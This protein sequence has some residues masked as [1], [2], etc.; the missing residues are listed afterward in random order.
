VRI[1]VPYAPGGATDIVAHLV[2]DQMRELLGQ[3]FIVES[4]P[5]D[6]GIPAIEQ[7]A[8]AKPDGYTLVVGNVSTNVITPIIFRS[9]FRIDY[10]KDVVPVTRL[11]DL[12]EFLLVTTTDFAPR[13]LPE[14]VAYA[15]E[16]PGELRYGA[17]GAGSYPDFDMTLFA[18][19]AGNLQ[20]TPVHNKTGA[21]GVIDDLV[22]GETQVAF[23]NVASSAAMVKAGKIVPLAVVNHERLLDYPSVP[24]M[25]SVG[26]PGIGTTAWQA[27][28]APAGTPGEVLDILQRAAARAMQ[29]PSAQRTIK[30]RSLN[31]V[32][33]SSVQEAR[34]WLA[35]EMAA[36]RKITREVKIDLPD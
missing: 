11:A 13:S 33:S 29:A 10:E 22:S 20:M 2:A 14:L 26:Y 35:G 16:H 25:Q 24:T 7:M 19:R 1:L 23:L 15:K 28:F 8:R 21:A 6:F 5:G 36:W 4:K 9:R 27:M 12:P 31:V 3:P 30:Q 32:P 34:R 17:V 18:K